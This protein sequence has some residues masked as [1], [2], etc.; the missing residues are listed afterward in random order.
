MG[1]QVGVLV[2]YT[3]GSILELKSAVLA[4][5]RGRGLPP[6]LQHSDYLSTYSARLTCTSAAIPLQVM[7]SVK[8]HCV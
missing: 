6:V 4:M 3:S 7:Q 5:A 1:V 8:Q 2:L